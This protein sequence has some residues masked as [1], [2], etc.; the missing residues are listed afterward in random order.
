MKKILAITQ[1]LSWSNLV[2]G[3]ILAL[4]ALLTLLSLP[5]L[6]VLLSVV[7]IG[8]I[9]LHSYAALQLRKSIL[10]EAIP[11]NKQT[12]VG[13]RMMGYMSLFFAIMLFANAI[14][15][16]QNTR[17]LVKQVKIPPQVKP[18]DFINIVHGTAIF[19]LVFSLSVIINVSL[20][21]RLLKWYTVSRA[22]KSN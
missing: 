5:A 1:I 9:V 15:L 13:I 2:I 22:N 11:L 18:S 20:N 3:A 7:L 6:A 10:N 4:F 12:P 19:I 14:F 21:L 17:E 8:C 16:L